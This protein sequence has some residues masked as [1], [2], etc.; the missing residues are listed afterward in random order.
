V[1][2][3]P[4]QFTRIGILNAADETVKTVSGFDL[5]FWHRAKATV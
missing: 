4:Q 3:E 1:S 2:L 5:P